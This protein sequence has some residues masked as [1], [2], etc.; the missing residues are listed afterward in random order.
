MIS[1]IR[2]LL[3]S[4]SVILL[5]ASCSA[6]ASTGDP[7]AEKESAFPTKQALA[8]SSGATTVISDEVIETADAEYKLLA[9][10]Y[11]RASPSVVNIESTFPS[12]GGS[13]GDV[14]RGSGF[15]YDRDGHIITNAHLVKGAESLT[16]TLQNA[17]VIDAELL[18]LDSFSDL[19]VLQITAPAERLIPLPVGDSSGVNVGQ[20]AISIGSPFGLNNT[21]TMG[22]VSG[23]GRSLRSAELIDG[24]MLPGFDNPSI[25]QIDATINPGTSGGPLLDSRGLVIGITTAIRSDNGA[26]QGVGFAV[27]ADTLR[28]VVPDLIENGRVEY[29]WM[30]LS[31]MPEDGGFGVAGLS[32]ALELPVERGVLL[33][34]V[35][36]GSPAN[37]AGLHGGQTVVE[38]RGKLVCAGGDV[39]VAINDF[40]IKNLDDLNSFLI[41]KTRPGDEI[42]LLVIRDKQTFQAKLTLQTRP[43]AATGKTLDCE[44]EP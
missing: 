1:R 41:Q 9:A 38:V 26:F 25:I 15:V 28:R 39:I 4:T 3:L 7:A 17:W 30:G 35:T 14:R 32:E 11:Q 22:I 31:V 21:L 42:E 36:L 18:G 6:I 27:P 10:I 2:K 16:V 34:G 33:K 44:T 8:E 23:L 19:A 12:I 40:H 37:R 13:L 29:A 24:S 5:L 20:R 43:V